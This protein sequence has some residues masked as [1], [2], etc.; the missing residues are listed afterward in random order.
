MKFLI[1]VL[2]AASIAVAHSEAAVT[3]SQVTAH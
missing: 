3:E 2:A 1:Q